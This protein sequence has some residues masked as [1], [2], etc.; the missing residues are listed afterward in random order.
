MQ[1]HHRR[2]IRIPLTPRQVH[3]IPHKDFLLYGLNL[4]VLRVFTLEEFIPLSLF[5]EVCA[6][7]LSSTTYRGFLAAKA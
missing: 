5:S 7:S 4:K 6:T 3:F 2:P 1:W